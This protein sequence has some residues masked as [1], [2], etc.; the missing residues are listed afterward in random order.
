MG[1]RLFLEG[2]TNVE[3]GFFSAIT[4]RAEAFSQA[5]G[6]GKYI[7][8]WYHDEAR[9]LLPSSRYVPSERVLVI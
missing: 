2:G 7:N 3:H 4:E 5:T 6:A 9:A 8:D 1:N